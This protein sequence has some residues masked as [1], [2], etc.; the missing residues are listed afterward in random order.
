MNEVNKYLAEEVTNLYKAM[1][2]VQKQSLN[3]IGLLMEEREYLLNKVE[4]LENN[5]EDAVLLVR[6]R[7]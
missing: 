4:K 6:S 5:K 2:T 7:L 3:L 1:E